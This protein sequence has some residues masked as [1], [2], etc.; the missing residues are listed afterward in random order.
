MDWIDVAQ[1]RQ[2]LLTV[3][4]LQVLSSQPPTR[5][6]PTTPEL[7]C[8]F[9]TALNEFSSACLRFSLY[10][11]GA[12]ATENTASTFSILSLWTVP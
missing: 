4:I 10:F 9:A 7:D 11:L 8:Q 5:N 6:S 2:R 12:D 3:K 1:D